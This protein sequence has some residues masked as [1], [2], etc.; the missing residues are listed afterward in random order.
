MRCALTPVLPSE[1]IDYIL[2]QTAYP[3][4]LIICQPR[5]EFI[6]AFCNCFIREESAT[7]LS[8]SRWE[9]LD[10]LAIS[11]KW[12]CRFRRKSILWY[13]LVILSRSKTERIWSSANVLITEMPTLILYSTAVHFVPTVSHLRALLTSIAIT[14]PPSAGPPNRHLEPPGKRKPAINV[15]G[16]VRLHEDTSQ[17][18]TQGFGNTISALVDAGIQS[19][20]DVIGK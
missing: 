17:W 14:P 2:K 10:Q 3:S 1:L 8:T 7:E 12:V 15:Y 11:K 13:F 4:T 19:R 16:L 20:R 18:S 6:E 9:A 5:A